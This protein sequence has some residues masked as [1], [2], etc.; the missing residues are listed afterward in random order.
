ML[1]E[2]G[3]IKCPTVFHVAEK[4][5]WTPPEVVSAL[6]GAFEGRSEVEIYV[7]PGVDHGFARKGAPSAC[8]FG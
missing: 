2:A 3:K 1:N 7:Y 4:D 5:K 6:K 8:L